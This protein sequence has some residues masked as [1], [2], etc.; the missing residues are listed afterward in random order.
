MIRA[1]QTQSESGSISAQFLMK[2]EDSQLNKLFAMA[3]LDFLGPKV[4]DIYMLDLLN[5]RRHSNKGRSG[6]FSSKTANGRRLW[7]LV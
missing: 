7:H 4:L 1:A 3:T 6:T 2:R 5:A